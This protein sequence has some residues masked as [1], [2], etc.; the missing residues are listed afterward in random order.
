MLCD[1]LKKINPSWDD[2]RL[3]QEARKLLIGMYQ[4]V[5]YNEFVPGL[6]GTYVIITNTYFMYVA[7]N[8]L[9]K[10]IFYNILL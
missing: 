1:D 5:V 8:L 6:L 4:H 10:Y 2:E 7:Y 3:Y 9:K